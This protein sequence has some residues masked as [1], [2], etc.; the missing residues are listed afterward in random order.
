MSRASANLIN[1]RHCKVEPQD[2]DAF[3]LNAFDQFVRD[4]GSRI[5]G[6]REVELQALDQ[7]E[8]KLAATVESLSL[9][10][11]RDGCAANF[12]HVEIGQV[13]A[14]GGFGKAFEG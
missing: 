5:V 4:P 8:D 9:T 11:A 14:F 12:G 7:V 6:D 13:Q 10:P 2:G 3:R 1:C